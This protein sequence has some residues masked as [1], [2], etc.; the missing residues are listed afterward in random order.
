MMGFQLKTEHEQGWYIGDLI[1]M[2]I[3]DAEIL[4]L[5]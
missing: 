4:M 5:T 1:N 2:C 3:T